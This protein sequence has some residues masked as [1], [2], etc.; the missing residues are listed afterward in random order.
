MGWAAIWMIFGID[1]PERFVFCYTLC[2][3]VKKL[4]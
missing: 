1:W 2:E 4:I 3:K